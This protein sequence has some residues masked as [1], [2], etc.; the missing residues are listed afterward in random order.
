MTSYRAA[1]IHHIAT[2]AGCRPCA[3]R[4]TDCLLIRQSFSA[5]AAGDAATHCMAAPCSDADRLDAY[6]SSTRARCID[7]QRDSCCRRRCC[8]CCCCCSEGRS[9]SSVTRASHT[10]VFQPASRIIDSLNN[11]H[12]Y[13]VV[14]RHPWP[15]SSDRRA[16]LRLRQT[17]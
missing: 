13:C 6:L 14:R 17:T 2:A 1:N 5:I 15:G 4:R 12:V 9:G 7:R 11:Y 3:A 16:S 10:Y 8:C